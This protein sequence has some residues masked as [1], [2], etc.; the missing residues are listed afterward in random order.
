MIQYALGITKLG[1]FIDHISY[2]L[3][4]AGL[5]AIFVCAIS[6]YYNLFHS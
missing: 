3:D 2:V 5:S 4:M 6:I 1:K